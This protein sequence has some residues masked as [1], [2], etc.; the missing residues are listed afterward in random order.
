[1]TMRFKAWCLVTILIVA[2]GG[3]MVVVGMSTPTAEVTLTEIETL[4]LQTLTQQH[5]ILLQQKQIL[6]TQYQQNQAEMDKLIVQAKETF[7][8]VAKAHKLNVVFDPTTFQLVPLEPTS[9]PKAK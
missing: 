8:A 3:S 2:I 7:E 4:K 6:Q 1:M 9:V 5:T